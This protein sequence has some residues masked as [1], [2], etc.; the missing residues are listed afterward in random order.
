MTTT[1]QRLA[2]LVAVFAFG[3]L[4]VHQSTSTGQIAPAPM[5][6]QWQYEIDSGNDVSEATANRLGMD[7]WE[8]VTVYQQHEGDF[9]AIYKRPVR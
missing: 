3:L 8:L 7:G 6:V 1:R 2:V 4:V 9:R 5:V